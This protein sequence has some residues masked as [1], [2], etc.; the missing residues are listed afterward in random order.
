MTHSIREQ[1]LR[2]VLTTLTPVAHAHGAQLLR[3]PTSAIT[4]EQS[5]ALLLLPESETLSSRNNDR[6]ERQLIIRL[7]ALAR[8]TGD[9]AAESLAD[10]LLVSAHRALFADVN[11]GGLCL[12]LSELDADWEIEDADA[13]AAALPARYQIS[14]RTLASDL[15]TQG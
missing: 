15:A 11:L 3:S 12:G 7:I 8:E 4:R 1:I 13:I 10:A 9:I 2:A 5:P 14:Y 6:V